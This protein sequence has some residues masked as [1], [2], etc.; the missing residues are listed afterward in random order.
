MTEQFE[1][2][3]E[4]DRRQAEFE[5]VFFSA[6]RNGGDQSRRTRNRNGNQVAPRHGN[7]VGTPAGAA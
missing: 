5:N 6:K 1:V 4:E 7:D 2:I 3:G